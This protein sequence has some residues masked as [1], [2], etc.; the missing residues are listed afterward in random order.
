MKRRSI[1]F[2]LFAAISAVAV[3]FIGI[4]VLLNLFFYE[5]YYMMTRRNELREA[6]QTVHTNFRKD[7]LLYTSRCV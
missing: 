5:D 4:L 6:Y 7:C 3:V 1:R 2:Q